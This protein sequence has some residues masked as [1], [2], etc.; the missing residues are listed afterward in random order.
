MDEEKLKETI[1]AM[2]ADDGF[3]VESFKTC[4]AEE[5]D[6]LVLYLG[7]RLGGESINLPSLPGRETTVCLRRW[8]LPTEKDIGECSRTELL[9]SAICR[10]MNTGG[11]I[12]QLQRLLAAA[13]MSMRD[14][15]FDF[16]GRY[17]IESRLQDEDYL[18]EFGKLK[19]NIGIHWWENN[20]VSVVEFEGGLVDGEVSQAKGEPEKSAPGSGPAAQS[21]ASAESSE[22]AE[23]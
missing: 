20:Y 5:G 10:Y 18:H 15:E 3:Y 19:D 6:T 12:E 1:T 23:G 22:P 14:V 8:Y 21:Q 13:S 7:F 9:W 11:K 2:D 16:G 4:T 17:L